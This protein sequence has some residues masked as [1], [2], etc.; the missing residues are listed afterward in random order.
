M[1]CLASNWKLKLAHRNRSK[2]TA[3][4]PRGDVVLR[5]SKGCFTVIHCDEEVARMIYFGPE[6]IE[7]LLGSPTTSR[8]LSGIFGGL[9]L[10]IGIVMFGNM[11]WTM[12]VAVGVAYAILNAAYWACATLPPKF[13]WDLSAVEM[14][15]H[16]IEVEDEERGKEKMVKQDYEVM[17]TYTT[18]LYRAI[19]YSKSTGWVLPSDGMPN[20]PAWNEWLRRVGE[21]LIQDS[22]DFDPQATL[23]QILWEQKSPV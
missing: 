10:T 1:L 11:S 2:V 12:Q 21:Q 20:T 7:Y 8:V 4:A 19:M 17:P 16:E 18:A 5:S 15:R 23:S 13:S 9:T 22:P 14:E 6:E 3:S